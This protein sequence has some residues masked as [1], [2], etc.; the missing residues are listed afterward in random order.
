[1]LSYVLASWLAHQLS[2]LLP[3][4]PP[5]ALVIGYPVGSTFNTT[6]ILVLCWHGGWVVKVEL[7]GSQK[8]VMLVSWSAYLSGRGRRTIS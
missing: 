7:T 1:M 6:A 4:I 8:A 5:L 3:S 2:C